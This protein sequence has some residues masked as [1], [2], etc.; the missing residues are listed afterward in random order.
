MMVQIVRF[1]LPRDVI[2]EITRDEAKTL[3]ERGEIGPFDDFVPKKQAIIS[4][5]YYI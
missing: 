1:K 2:R 3:I 4:P 5:Q